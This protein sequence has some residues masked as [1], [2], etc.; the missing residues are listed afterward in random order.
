[1]VSSATGESFLGPGGLSKPT[2]ELGSVEEVFDPFRVILLPFVKSVSSR[3]VAYELPRAERG[4]SICS[5]KPVEFCG[6]C[7]DISCF[8]CLDPEAF[9]YNPD[10]SIED[11]S[12]YYFQF[13][14]ITGES[15]T[16]DDDDSQFS[17][18]I[19][20]DNDG[21]LD[22][23]VANNG[24]PNC[25]YQNSGDGTFIKITTAGDIVEDTD[26]SVGASWGDYDN[27][28]DM[29]LYLSNWGRNRL[30]RNDN[31]TFVNTAVEF[32]L[33]SDSLSN[34]ISKS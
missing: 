23:F 24:P 21:D 12:C 5:E 15:I 10:V 19:D 6:V 27:D 14:P 29:D 18:W 13:E 31:G 2:A 3:R 20:Y 22:L 17:S 26:S 16:G 30:F 7:G 4:L 33:Q 25:L 11:G 1:M 32:D 8:G 28:S 9:N 34:L